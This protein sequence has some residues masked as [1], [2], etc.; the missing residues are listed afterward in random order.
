[1]PRPAGVQYIGVI[2]GGATQRF[3]THS[4]PAAW[5]VFWTVMPLTTCSGAPQLT[6][7]I[8]MERA[9]STMATYWLELTNL[10]PNST[11]FEW[12]YKILKQ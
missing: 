8:Q 7:K 10:T 9:S 6:W 1:M 12:R 4:W 2:A 11:R 3:F 5:H